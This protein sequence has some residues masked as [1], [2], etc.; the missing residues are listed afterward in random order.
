MKTILPASIKTIEQAKK[1]LNE[2]YVNGEL[3]HPED[4]AKDC[5]NGITDD[6]AA[7]CNELMNEI[8]SLPGNENIKKLS[9]DP[10]EYCVELTNQ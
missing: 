10:C 9:F 4:D 2:L 8:Y 3:Y 6:E 7:K 1:F 5:L